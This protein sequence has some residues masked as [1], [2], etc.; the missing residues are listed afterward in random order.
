MSAQ[1]PTQLQID[2]LLISPYEYE[3]ETDEED[4]FLTITAKA[5]ISRAEREHFTL[6]LDGRY[7]RV[8]RVG[9]DEAP[10]EMRVAGGEM[11]WSLHDDG[12][13]QY[14][15]LIDKA[16]DDKR[17]RRP[18][19]E[20]CSGHSLLEKRI[21]EELATVTAKFEAALELMAD[22]GVLTVDELRKLDD[23]SQND[24]A[25]RR[26]EIARLNDIDATA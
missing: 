8:V 5:L 25:R 10:R 3:E 7:L 24:R 12:V 21:A 4:G 26:E 15:V 6:L 11:W 18:V 20:Y 17:E 16:S 23:V 19:V 2:D 14:I 22:K 1:E 13:K 9:V